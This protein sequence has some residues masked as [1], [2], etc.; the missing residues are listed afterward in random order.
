MLQLFLR[1]EAAEEAH[2]HHLAGAWLDRGQRIERLGDG[3][4]VDRRSG[5]RQAVGLEVGELCAAAALC[6][7]ARAGDIDQDPPHHPRRRCEE[8]RPVLPLDRLPLEQTQVGL[9]DQFG[10]LHPAV[11]T[12][13]GQNTAGHLAEFSMNQRRQLIERL[14]ITTTPGLQ[15]AGQIRLRHAR[16]LTPLH[17][18]RP[19]FRLYGRTGQLRPAT[20]GGVMSY[21]ESL[22]WSRYLVAAWPSSVSPDAAKHQIPQRPPR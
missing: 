10:R 7:L 20:H 16:I 9:V 12:L 22:G 1:P 4:D 19:G 11:A 21:A 6:G 2:L 14:L 15:Q 13:I 5:R 8:V 18:R 3:F 17:R